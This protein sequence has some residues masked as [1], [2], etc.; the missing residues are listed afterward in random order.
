MT[1]NKSNAI[2]KVSSNKSILW[3]SLNSEIFYLSNVSQPID[4]CKYD[5]AL[6]R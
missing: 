1:K 2:A 3:N 5:F 6:R 4:N